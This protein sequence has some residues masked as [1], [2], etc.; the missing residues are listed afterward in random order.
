M[1]QSTTHASTHETTRETLVDSAGENRIKLRYHVLAIIV[2]SVIVYYLLSFAT[3]EESLDISV[4]LEMQDQ[5]Y[6][7]FM[8]DV[9]ST[10][11]TLSGE[12]DYLLKARRVTHFPNPEYSLM[13]SP[14]F[15]LFQPDNST[16]EIRS[17]NGRVDRDYENNRQRLTLNDNVIISGI[18]AEGRPLNIY[19]D[20]LTLYPEEK[21]MN[22]ESDVLF[23][24]D[25]FS[26][27]SIG[28]TANLATNVIR[29]LANGRFT[30][31]Q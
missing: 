14:H 5:G 15:L 20:S 21:S 9:D 8:S 1:P 6:D 10:H 29:Q 28:F 7:Y 22:T 31:E 30:Y 23:E 13:E 16:W 11:Y 3:D 4:L 24:S 2:L 19:T 27:T 25:G 26:S 17:Q 12:A 18:S